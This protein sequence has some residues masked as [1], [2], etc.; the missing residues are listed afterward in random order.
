MQTNR[1]IVAT[2]LFVLAAISF[3]CFMHSNSKDKEIVVDELDLT[4][5]FTDDFTEFLKSNSKTIFI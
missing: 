5:G 3:L 2:T 4:C 1:N